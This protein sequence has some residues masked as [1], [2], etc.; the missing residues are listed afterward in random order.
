[1]ELSSRTL[2]ISQN[3]KIISKWGKLTS[4]GLH[5]E[6]KKITKGETMTHQL[7]YKIVLFYYM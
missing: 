2:V 7:S 5:A 6:K 4:L 3:H 1:M